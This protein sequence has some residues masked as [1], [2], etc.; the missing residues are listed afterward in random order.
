M[1]VLSC[2]EG[3][4]KALRRVYSTLPTHTTEQHDHGERSTFRISEHH[5][6]SIASQGREPSFATRG[7]SKGNPRPLWEGICTSFVLGDCTTSLGESGH[8]PSTM[9]HASS[10]LNRSTL[11][12]KEIAVEECEISSCRHSHSD[13]LSHLSAVCSCAEFP[14]SMRTSSVRPVLP[15]TRSMSTSILPCLDVRS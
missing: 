9:S 3:W 4:S 6:R 2:H 11:S 12:L 10:D 14:G 1:S 13:E 15:S 8:G 7:G 5:L